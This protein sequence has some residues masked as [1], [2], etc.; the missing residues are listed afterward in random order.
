MPLNLFEEICLWKMNI[1]FFSETYSCEQFTVKSVTWKKN[2]QHVPT[3]CKYK[4][5]SHHEIKSGIIDTCSVTGKE[6]NWNL[7]WVKL[8]SPFWLHHYTRQK[9]CLYKMLLKKENRCLQK[10]QLDTLTMILLT[11]K[12]RTT[13]AECTQSQP[14]LLN[15][16][17]STPSKSERIFSIN[18]KPVSIQL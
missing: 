16:K 2:K 10:I 12:C 11:F 6:K 4:L 1:H 17:I 15:R 14:Y 8:V 5:V 7:I 3:R 9:C 18:H 13:N